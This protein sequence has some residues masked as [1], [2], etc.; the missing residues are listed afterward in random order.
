MESRDLVSR[1]FTL[2][3]LEAAAVQI[4]RTLA[5]TPQIVWPLLSERCGCE[6][7]VKHENHLPTGAFKV[8]G[9]M[10]LM[11]LLTQSGEARAGVVAATRGNHG[12]SIAFAAQ[13][14]DVP[15]V[16][17]VPHGNNPDKNRAM[18]ALGAELMEYGE[19]FSA[20]L[21]HAAA[22]GEERGLFALPSFHPTLVQGVAS[23]GL[24]LLRSAPLD[25]VYAPIGLGSG[26]SGVLA[27]RD[28]LGLNTELVGV[29]AAGADA[30]ASSFEQGAVVTTARADTLADGLA[31]RVPDADAL[32][33]L[34]SG[35]SRVVRVD[36]DA[37]LA[38]IAALFDDTH[39]IAEGAGAAPLAALLTERERM[40][41]KRVGIILSGG[42]LD[43]ATLRRAFA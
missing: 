20:A 6:V 8:R 13:R 16:I 39:N 18:K 36:D 37:I 30:Y 41:G 3:E 15:A 14:H 38:A 5:P 32:A 10:W 11:H 7:W 19:D 28:A 29:V 34:R 40:A 43:R 17:V 9:G 2:P 33:W 4:Y 25:A 21:A 12:Q 26:L 24:E 31:V 22:L 42:N 27:A 35:V 23:Y 1:P